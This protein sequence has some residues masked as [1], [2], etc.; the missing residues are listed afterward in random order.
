[1]EAAEEDPD[2]D[3]YVI[4]IPYYDKNPDGAFREEHYEG[5]LYPDYVPITRY[6]E[7]DFEM[8]QPDITF[9]HNPY[10]ECNY[11]TSVHPLFYAKELKNYTG[12]LVYIPYFIL[13][14]I[15]PA[16]EEMVKGI[17]HFCIAPG[18][19]HADKVIVQSEKMRQIYINVLVKHTGK[20]K[21]H[22]GN[23]ILGLGSPKTDKVLRI[24]KNDIEVP[25]EWLELIRKPSGEWKKVILYNTSVGALLAQDE[26]MIKKM[27]GVFRIFKAMQKEITLL[28]RPHPLIQ[29][30][31]EAMR[32][33][34]WEAY[35]EMMDEYRKEGWGIY[36]NTPDLSRAI[37]LSDG[38]YG[39]PSS[40]VQLYRN[41][42]MPIM[43]QNTE[44]Q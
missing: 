23:K 40:L 27:Q 14:E 21:R 31:L 35:R 20:N 19:I 12:Q 25:K 22:W 33:E 37:A 38:Y 7:Y 29:A 3:A 43:I 13:D 17:E 24:K 4:P 34:L 1:M 5:D 9:I 42:K 44:I 8:H 36:D 26:K 16:D 30:T 28:W 18:V 41:V 11:V 2:C 32:P 6:D 39:D 15:D 10:D